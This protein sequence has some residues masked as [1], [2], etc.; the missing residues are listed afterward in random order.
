MSVDIFITSLLWLVYTT[1]YIELYLYTFIWGQNY[2]NGVCDT[3][4]FAS[5]DCSQVVFQGFYL[6]I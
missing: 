2:C 6:C 1:Q 4:E 3:W 5:P